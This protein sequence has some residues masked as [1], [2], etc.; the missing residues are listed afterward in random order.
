VKPVRTD[1]SNFVYGLPGATGESDLPCRRENGRVISTWEA[2]EGDLEQLSPDAPCVVL[3]IL[4]ANP[5]GCS[6]KVGDGPVH[7]EES[8]G[9]AMVSPF[10]RDHYWE[11]TLVLHD[12]EVQVL[13]DGGR[14]EIMIDLMPP[15]PISVRLN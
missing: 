5:I 13:R 1:E 14:V 12:R 10:D 4:W 9:R 8:L 7:H 3:N 2:E 6:I 11:Y 15:P